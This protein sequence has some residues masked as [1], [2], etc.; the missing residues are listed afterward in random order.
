MEE[1]DNLGNAKWKKAPPTT[2]LQLKQKLSSLNR[3]QP[4]LNQLGV[5]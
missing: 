2:E 5:K 4:V 3:S 1:F